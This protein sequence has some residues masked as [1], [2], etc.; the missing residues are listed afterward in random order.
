MP[1]LFC[2]LYWQQCLLFYLLAGVAFFASLC[3]QLAVLFSVQTLL[4]VLADAAD[5]V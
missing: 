1:A 2:F 4:H 5:N 3:L